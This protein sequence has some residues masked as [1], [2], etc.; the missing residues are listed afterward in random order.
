MPHQLI[1]TDTQL[2]ALLKRWQDADIITVDTEFF[3]ERTYY[4]KLCLLQM[5][6]QDEAVAVDVLT[7]NA[8]APLKDFVCDRSRLKVFHSARQDLELLLHVWGEVPQPLFD[9]QVAADLVGAGEQSGYARLVEA[10]FGAV[11][12][13]DA[14]RSNWCGRP[15]SE[16]QLDYAY[17]D[18]T[19]LWKLYQHLD[20]E[21]TRLQRHA[22]MREEMELLESESLHRVHPQDAWLKIKGRNRLNAQQLTLL[23]QLTAWREE[24]AIKKDLPRK[25][26]LGDGFLLEYAQQQPQSVKEL[27]AIDKSAQRQLERYAKKLLQIAA[28]VRQLP[29]SSWI[30]EA[31]RPRL[32]GEQK[33]RLAELESQLQS[34][35]TR[36]SI[37]PGMIAS[38]SQLIKLMSGDSLHAES[39]WR[40]AIFDALLSDTVEAG[41]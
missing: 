6:W 1:E 5:C 18:V 27:L 33:R 19:W 38:R 35:A 23:Q 26:V 3:R 12:P 14:T 36:D 8:L 16:K 41:E 20:A 17:A 39:S 10:V 24:M 13:K 32:S 37:A 34:I 7:I 30:H 31:P 22:W 15:L 21:L 2:E 29:D 4:P 9:S 40:A 11:L 28:E 25:W